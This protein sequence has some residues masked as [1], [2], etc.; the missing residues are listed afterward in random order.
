LAIAVCMLIVAAGA[1]ISP[2]I[3]KAPVSTTGV[4]A[5]VSASQ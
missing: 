1:T 3:R 5:E 4:P 2:S